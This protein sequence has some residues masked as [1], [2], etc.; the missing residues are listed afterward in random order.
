MALCCLLGKKARRADELDECMDDEIEMARISQCGPT[1]GDWLG[2]RQSVSK[3]G[4]RQS[5]S[6]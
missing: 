4:W 5:C 2:G 6:R 1:D 3:A